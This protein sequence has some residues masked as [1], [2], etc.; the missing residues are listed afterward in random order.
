MAASQTLESRK[1]SVRSNPLAAG[2]YRERGKPR[3]WN[4]IPTGLRLRA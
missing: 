4:E 2:F 1:I 3:I